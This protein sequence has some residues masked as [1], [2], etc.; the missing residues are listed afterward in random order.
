MF[1]V[2][3]GVID[4]NTRMFEDTDT[5]EAQEAT[6]RLGIMRMLTCCEEILLEKKSPLSCQTPVFHFFRSSPRD[7]CITAC[8]NLYF[9]LVTT[10]VLFATLHL[11]QNMS[12]TYVV[13][14]IVASS[15][16][17]MT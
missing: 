4:V 16:H 17:T 1:T 10:T 6:T 2:G 11:W 8:V 7:L 13:L 3:I 9:F 5:S 14:S 15:G 12:L